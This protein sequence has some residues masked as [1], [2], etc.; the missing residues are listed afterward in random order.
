MES[1]TRVAG[2]GYTTLQFKGEPLAYMQ[3]AADQAPQPVAPAQAVQPMDEKH[4]IEIVTA[5]AVGPGTLRMTFYDT[6]DTYV[7][8]KL[9]GLENA[10]GLLDVLE[11][12]IALGEISCS[13]II[14]SPSGKMRALVYHNC[15]VT[16]V[17]A[18][19]TVNIGSMTLPKTITIQYTH[20][21]PV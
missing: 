6:W 5:K 18:G 19:E 13:K 14:K 12:Q 15:V 1:K 21:T 4:P 3:S 10:A 11:Q 2:S 9:P 20:V 7:W 16:D 17:D 8:N